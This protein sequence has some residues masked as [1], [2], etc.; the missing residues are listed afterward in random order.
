MWLAS[1]RWYKTIQNWKTFDKNI[2]RSVTYS[3]KDKVLF[4]CGE[5]QE[6]WDTMLLFFFSFVSPNAE[7][8]INTDCLR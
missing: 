8:I 2:K 5:H 4:N 1:R 3:S 6:V 7:V